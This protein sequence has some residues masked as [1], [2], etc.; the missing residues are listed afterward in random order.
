MTTLLD[1][2]GDAH[3]VNLADPGTVVAVVLEVLRPSDAIPDLRT[4]ALVAQGP[5]RV[6]VIPRH[7]TGSRRP[8]VGALAISTGKTRAACR[9]AVDVRSLADRVAVT[10]QGGRG[11]VVRYDEKHIELVLCS[12]G[13]PKIQKDDKSETTIE[14]KFQLKYG[15]H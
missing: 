10:G 13:V 15:P 2:A 5:G 9:Q 6:R 11:K 3:V 4:R 1:A 14:I 8:T 7:E 12:G